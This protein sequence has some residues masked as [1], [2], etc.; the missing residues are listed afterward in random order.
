MLECA[1][2]SQSEGFFMHAIHIASA[3]PELHRL[4]VLCVYTELSA[5]DARLRDEM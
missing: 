5:L 4:V 3:C 2:T 1:N